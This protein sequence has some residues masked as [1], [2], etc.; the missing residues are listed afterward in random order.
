VSA[1][2]QKIVTAAVA[3]S[4]A[5][6]R[7]I[8]REQWAADLN[9]AADLHLSR[10]GI[11]LGALTTA[12]LQGRSAN[13]TAGRGPEQPYTIRAVPLLIA[14]AF[15]SMFLGQGVLV[16]TGR[17]SGSDYM[18]PLMSVVFALE[19]L[20]P[21]LAVAMAILLIPGRSRRR[22]VIPSAVV[23][24]IGCAFFLSFA[25]SHPPPIWVVLGLS[26]VG[27]LAMWFVATGSRGRVW[28]L[29]VV[30]ALVVACFEWVYQPLLGRDLDV[31]AIYVAFSA[32]LMLPFAA[33]AIVGLVAAR[34]PRARDRDEVNA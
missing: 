19:G 31:H 4:P 3:L 9:G 13:A 30:P 23:F 7:E 27:V 17:Y 29:L 32:Q 34:P 1:L 16:L 5:D 11:A 22:R 10:V 8:R 24:A 6:L 26:S 33:V 25:G 2:A 12:L 18:Q 20:V 21:A 15:G 28:A 14:L